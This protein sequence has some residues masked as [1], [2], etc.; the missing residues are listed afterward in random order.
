V[1]TSPL[2]GAVWETFVYAELRK[3][4][5][6]RGKKKGLWYYRD[7][8]QLEADFIWESDHGMQLI[9]CKW[10]GSPSRQMADNLDKLEHVMAGRS[11][12]SGEIG[13]KLISR[14]GESFSS[15]GLLYASP[16]HGLLD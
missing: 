12:A 2:I 3:Q 14:A 10:T 15:K 6:F 7:Q 13:K 16:L 11:N 5:S 4:L 8:S 1:R 9:E